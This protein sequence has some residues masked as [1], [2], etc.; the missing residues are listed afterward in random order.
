MMNAEG[1]WAVVKL[2][3]GVRERWR[4]DL[5]RGDSG[6]CLLERRV[7]SSQDTPQASSVPLLLWF[8]GFKILLSLAS[9]SDVLLLLVERKWQAPEEEKE[10]E[11]QEKYCRSFGM[12]SSFPLR[13]FLAVSQGGVESS[14]FLFDTLIPSH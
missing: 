10:T 13:F 3:S 6:R 14:G 4:L 8:S 12:P 1:M 9:D 5:S 7:G 2:S 11:K